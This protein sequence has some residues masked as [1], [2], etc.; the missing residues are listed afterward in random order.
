MKIRITGK[1]NEVNAIVELIK[2]LPVGSV[3]SVSL[4]YR[5]TR[6]CAYSDE[7]RVYVDFSL[8]LASEKEQQIN[9]QKLEVF[10]SIM[11]TIGGSH[12]K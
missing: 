8:S 3:N 5:N 9:N 4:P 1:E 12:G 2:A 6:K 10:Q 11:K 7:V